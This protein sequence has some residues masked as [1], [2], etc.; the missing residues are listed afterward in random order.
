MIYNVDAE[1]LYRRLIY[2]IMDIREAKKIK[3]NALCDLAGITYR[4]Y[5]CLFWRYSRK[6]AQVNTNIKALLAVI[7]A[8]GYK[9]VLRRKDDAQTE[10][11]EC[12]N[13]CAQIR[14]GDV[15]CWKC[16]RRMRV[17]A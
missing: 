16:G 12:Y 2:D 1:D 15:Y 6:K 14:V 7:D 13:C 10:S 17:D 8:L 3:V 11:A 5:E 4:N 9:L